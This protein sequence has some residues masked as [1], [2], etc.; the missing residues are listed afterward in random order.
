LGRL[1]N[2]ENAGKERTMLQRALLLALREMM[3]KTSTDAETYDLA[4]FVSFTLI[5]IGG[6]IE[7]SVIAWEK[8]GYWVKA[9][10]FRME[11]SWALRLGNKMKTA[12]L[13]NDWIEVAQIAGQT[14]V[15]LENVKLPVRNKLGT[16]WEGSWSKL[17]K[18]P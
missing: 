12:I 4:A 14:M 8:R 5:A 2:P 6:T 11:W 16:P 18:S 1:I 13:N 3:K 7:P 17:T 9:D 15:K 10:R